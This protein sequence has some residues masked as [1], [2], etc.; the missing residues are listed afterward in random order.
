MSG[1]A[2][3]PDGAVFVADM[4]KLLVFPPPVYAGRLFVSVTIGDTVG[5]LTAPTGVAMDQKTS[6]VF[7]SEGAFF[8]NRIS[9]FKRD[10]TLIRCF[11]SF[12]F[13]P[14]QLAFPRALAV[15]DAHVYLHDSQSDCL[16]VFTKEGKLARV[17]DTGLERLDWRYIN[18]LCVQ[19][20]RLITIS[21]LR[22]AAINVWFSMFDAVFPHFACRFFTRMALFLVKSSATAAVESWTNTRM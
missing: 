13:K 19:D 11:G 20:K 15:D 18:Q 17:I 12:G 10:G 21:T 14:E 1:I 2:V 4:V 3:A 8:H 22:D 6:E 7:V 9:V 16:K 5:T